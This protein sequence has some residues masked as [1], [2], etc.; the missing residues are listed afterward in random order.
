[1]KKVISLK[2]DIELYEHIQKE[3]EK[4]YTTVTAYICQ[5]AAKDKINKSMLANL[6]LAQSVDAFKIN[7]PGN[8]ELDSKKIIEFCKDK[9]VENAR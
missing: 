8:I 6:D 2:I 7:M 3:A 5:L 4:N 9:I 1:M